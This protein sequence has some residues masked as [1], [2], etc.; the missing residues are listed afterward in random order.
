MLDAPTALAA[1]CGFDLCHKYI[2]ICICI[3]ILATRTPSL[4]GVT[5]NFGATR[6]DRCKP[7]AAL[8]TKPAAVTTRANCRTAELTA[9][10]N[11]GGVRAERWSVA[12][13]SGAITGPPPTADRH[14][15]RSTTSSPDTTL[16]LLPLDDTTY[17]AGTVVQTPV[18]VAQ[19]DTDVVPLG[20]SDK[21]TVDSAPTAVSN[22]ATS[23]APWAPPYSF[24]L[25]CAIGITTAAR[26]IGSTT[27]AA[28]AL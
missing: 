19:M 25:V 24:P 5:S 26:A 1:C 22:W 15:G 12:P 27:A 13:R 9:T 3:C 21:C 28:P 17:G 2:C 11:G 6:I 4:G 10:A 20:L 16:L 8:R 18:S 7:D 23:V 14:M